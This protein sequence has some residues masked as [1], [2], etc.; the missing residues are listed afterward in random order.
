MDSLQIIVNIVIAIAGSLALFFFKKIHSTQEEFGR[1]IKESNVLNTQALATFKEK[2]HEEIDKVK[3]KIAVV[4]DKINGVEKE[5]EKKLSDHSLQTTKEFA[6]KGDIMALNTNFSLR[7]T[8]IEGKLDD[9][10]DEKRK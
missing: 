3:D 1:D 10:I 9:L 7:F 2:F 8:S 5:M 6:T 4:N